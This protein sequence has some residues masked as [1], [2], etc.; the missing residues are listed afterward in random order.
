M[1]SSTARAHASREKGRRP[2]AA[3]EGHIVYTTVAGQGWLAG[4]VKPARDA[5]IPTAGPIVAHDRPF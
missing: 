3:R 2:I 5:G 1:P 4:P